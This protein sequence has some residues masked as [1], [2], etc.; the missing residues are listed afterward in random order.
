MNKINNVN[1]QKTIKNVKIR[2]IMDL[3]YNS[4]DRGINLKLNIFFYWSIICQYNI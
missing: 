2:R 4:A 1:E 3:E